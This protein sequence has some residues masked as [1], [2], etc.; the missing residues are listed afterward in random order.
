VIAATHTDT[1]C[2]PSSSPPP[3]RPC[4]QPLPPPPYLHA[5]GHKGGVVEKI[6]LKVPSVEGHER[7]RA[8]HCMDLRAATTATGNH[9]HPLSTQPINQRPLVAPPES[10]R[11]RHTRHEHETREQPQGKHTGTQQSANKGTRD[12]GVGVGV[13]GWRWVGDGMG[14]GEGGGVDGV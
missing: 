1:H 2:A 13:E 11:H 7:I 14:F 12:A 4:D 6:E 9:R 8:R 5:A 3:D 10:G